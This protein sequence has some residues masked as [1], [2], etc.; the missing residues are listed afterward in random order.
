MTGCTGSFSGLSL[1]P[2]GSP[3]L[4][5]PFDGDHPLRMAAGG[6][7]VGG[8]VQTVVVFECVLNRRFVR[9]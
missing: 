3:A 5:P 6:G 8:I 9:H 7:S 1:F 2:L 4:S